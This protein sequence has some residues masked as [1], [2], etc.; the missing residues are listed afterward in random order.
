M[1]KNLNVYFDVSWFFDL[2]VN[3]KNAF[4]LDKYFDL[5]DLK[6]VKYNDCKDL[7][8]LPSV[9]WLSKGNLIDINHIKMRYIVQIFL[10][11]AMRKILKSCKIQYPMKQTS[12][13]EGGNGISV[14]ISSD[15]NIYLAGLYQSYTYCEPIRDILLADFSFTRDVPER[16][17]E[18]LNAIVQSN[19]VSI[20]IRQGDYTNKIWKDSHGSVCTMEYYHNAIN[21]LKRKYSDLKFFLFSDDPDWVRDNFLFLDNYCVVDN[22]SEEYPDYYDLFLMTKSK[23]TIMSN[24]TFAWWGAW[25][26]QNPSQIVI[27]PDR[28]VMG[29]SEKLIVDKICPPEWI[30]IPRS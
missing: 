19:S 18:I 22:R 9:Y 7:I 14:N 15:T 6:I 29:H 23:H 16:V 13:L 17:E 10:Q 12:F 26:N 8:D 3:M 11:K 25:L 4:R 21:Y 5:K 2:A 24:S 27:V 30:R 20:H 28:W 1:S